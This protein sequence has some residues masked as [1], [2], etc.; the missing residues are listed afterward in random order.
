[1]GL[2]VGKDGRLR[3]VKRGKGSEWEKGSVKGEKRGKG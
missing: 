1:M 3:V 2:R